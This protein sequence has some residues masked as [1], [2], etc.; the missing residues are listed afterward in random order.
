M[1]AFEDFK[2][3]LEENEYIFTFEEDEER[4]V[5]RFGQKLDN[6]NVNVMLFF[7]DD[8]VK[9]FVHN[10]ANI[11]DESKMPA[12]LQLANDCNKQYNFF[13]FYIDGDN[14]F[15]AEDDVNIDVTDG[16]LD[17]EILMGILVAGFNIIERIYPKLMKTLWA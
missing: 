10:I 6:T 1:S 9:I 14:D 13:K 12:C 17:P 3:F 7:N 16:S 15:V 2:E 4:P 8:F 5:I 11:S